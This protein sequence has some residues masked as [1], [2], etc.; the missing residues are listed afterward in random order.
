MTAKGQESHLARGVRVL[1]PAE[2][3]RSPVVLNGDELGECLFLRSG[4]DEAIHNRNAKVRSS[5]AVEKSDPPHVEAL[6][7]LNDLKRPLGQEDPEHLP[8]PI[9]VVVM[10]E[11]GTL[12]IPRSNANERIRDNRRVHLLA[13]SQVVRPTWDAMLPELL[14]DDVVLPERKFAPGPA[15]PERAL[16]VHDGTTPR[17]EGLRP[18]EAQDDG[19]ERQGAYVRLQT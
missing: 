3:R 17:I 5:G 6:S 11:H 7:N 12:H 16:P 18:D 14:D 10:A 1:R 4:D 19:H 8:F 15:G 13:Q 2:P 9:C